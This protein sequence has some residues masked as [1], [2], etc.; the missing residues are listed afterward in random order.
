MEQGK[1]DYGADSRNYCKTQLG[2]NN[3]YCCSPKKSSSSSSSAS[4]KY[5]SNFECPEDS[6][7][8]TWNDGV[9]AGK[10]AD[11]SNGKPETIA[12]CID[13]LRSIHS[14]VA[15]FRQKFPHNPPNFSCPNKFTCM[16]ISACATQG[17]GEYY[18]GN[19]TQ[20][21]VAYCRGVL[22]TPPSG[23]DSLCCGV[24]SSAPPAFTCPINSM[25]MKGFECY[26]KGNGI[27]DFTTVSRTHCA[28][29]LGYQNS[30]CCKMRSSSSVSLSS[31][32]V[33]TTCV[34]PNVCVIQGI[35]GMMQGTLQ[36]TLTCPQGNGAALYCCKRPM[37][38]A[39]SSSRQS[40][41]LSVVRLPPLPLPSSSAA[42]QCPQG[43]SCKELMDC[44]SVPRSHFDWSNGVPQTIAHC[45]AQLG[46]ATRVG[47]CRQVQAA[48][49]TVIPSLGNFFGW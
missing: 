20:E 31:S 2:V 25:C 12:Y 10:I 8:M 45:S 26:T 9:S 40:S 3:A 35:C 27:A 6:I 43:T 19:N 11:Y 21:T 5:P 48:P 46:I 29:V 28:A 34:A 32:S 41:S 36:P 14:N 13:Q 33:T 15:C 7:C 24:N 17:N 23:E 1:V 39:S 16:P 22:R 42:F 30:Y 49:T 18:Y 4:K 47:C 44:I 38:S 37:S